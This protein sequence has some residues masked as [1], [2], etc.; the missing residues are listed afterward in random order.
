MSLIKPFR[1]IRPA[2]GRAGE[3]AAPPYD[4]LSADEARRIVQDGD[5]RKPWSFLHVSK[6][7][8]DLPPDIDH[9]SPQVYAKS[10]ENYLKMFAEGVLMQ[11]DAP[12]CYAYRL[13]M[14]EHVQT[15]L[16]AAAS[17]AD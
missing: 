7:E 1:G 4:V 9:Y 10:R 6:A 16:V 8:I 5:A 17:V 13:V 12:C 11:D 14:G 15:G 3:V 2:P